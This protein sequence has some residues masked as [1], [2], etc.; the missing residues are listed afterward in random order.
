MLAPLSAVSPAPEHSL[1]TLAL[2]HRVLLV[3]PL[4]SLPRAPLIFP[5]LPL[6]AQCR[7]PRRPLPRPRPR[8]RLLGGLSGLKVCPRL[9][10]RHLRRSRSQARPSLISLFCKVFTPS[11]VVAAINSRIVAWSLSGVK[12]DTWRVHST[13]LLPPSQAIASLDIKSGA[14]STSISSHARFSYLVQQGSW[15]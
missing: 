6:R 13:L 3:R 15:L 4:S 7:R 12:H 5:A 1:R 2:R 9:H 11:Q 10:L 14:L 8:P